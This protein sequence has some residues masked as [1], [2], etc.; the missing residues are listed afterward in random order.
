MISV[1]KKEELLRR[2]IQKWIISWVRQLTV[3][4]EEAD[5]KF[6]CTAFVCLLTFS[7]YVGE[8]QKQNLTSVQQLRTSSSGDDS[9]YQKVNAM[10]QAPCSYWGNISFVW[11]DAVK[12][13]IYRALKIDLYTKKQ[14]ISVTQ[15]TYSYQSVSQFAF[16]DGSTCLQ[17]R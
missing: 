16:D 7:K 1:I 13:D 5:S 3:K 12:Q 11:K 10:A 17:Y 15:K 2:S 9:I 14:T 6:V 4:F 8:I